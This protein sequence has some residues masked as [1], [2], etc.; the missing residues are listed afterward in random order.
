[1]CL[2]QY[3]GV[4]KRGRFERAKRRTFKNIWITLHKRR[5]RNFEK[6]VKSAEKIQYLRPMIDYYYYYDH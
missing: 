3:C 6:C 1:M 4:E 2:K 5:R